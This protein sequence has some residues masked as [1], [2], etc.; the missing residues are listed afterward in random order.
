MLKIQSPKYISKLHIGHSARIV[1]Y[2]AIPLGY[3]TSMSEVEARKKYLSTLRQDAKAFNQEI[4][5]IVSL[6]GT[7]SKDLLEQISKGH[8]LLQCPFD[9]NHKVP[10]ETYSAHFKKCELRAL[11]ITSEDNKP[12]PSSLGFYEKAPAVISLIEGWFPS[13]IFTNHFL[14]SISLL[15]QSTGWNGSWRSGLQSGKSVFCKLYLSCKLYT[16]ASLL[17]SCSESSTRHW[18]KIDLENLEI[19]STEDL[20]GDVLLTENENILDNILNSDNIDVRLRKLNKW[21][22]IPRFYEKLNIEELNPMKTRGW[23]V[24]NLPQNTQ[25]RNSISPS[26]N[27]EMEL[28]DYIYRHLLL[29]AKGIE[30]FK[31]HVEPYFGPVN[32][33]ILPTNQQSSIDEHSEH[34]QLPSEISIEPVTDNTGENLVY[35]LLDRQPRLQPG[36]ALAVSQRR[37]K[38]EHLIQAS[39]YIR[40]LHGRNDHN[41]Y[42]GF[43]EA[44]ERAKLIKEQNQKRKSKADLLAEQRD[45][46]RRRK[47][48]RAKNVRITQR[49]P[50]QI[51]RDLI[52]A[53]MEDFELLNS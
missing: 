26:F 44:L 47:S 19:E 20:H 9:H 16:D 12:L 8:K 18:D 43:E 32:D 33:A 24:N 36:S 21:T 38:Y 40:E 34:S 17:F 1:I 6:L 11:G 39:R 37:K 29:P 10:K 30:E 23:L 50:T 31:R 35:N 46:K 48:Y 3:T 27:S 4:E 15:T 25:L 28:S 5:S 52:A 14:Q 45:Y 2:I 13:L 53:Y 51:Q 7:D 49:T 42:D 22:Q 41:I